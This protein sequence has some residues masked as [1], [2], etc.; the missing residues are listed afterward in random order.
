M[1]LRVAEQVLEP[2]R[3]LDPD[4]EHAVGRKQRAGFLQERYRAAGARLGVLE[5]ADGEDDVERLLRV[6]VED[7]PGGDRDVL[8]SCAS[9]RCRARPVD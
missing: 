3:V 6:E 7:R 1:V 8:E 2:D 4:G 9:S 5:Q